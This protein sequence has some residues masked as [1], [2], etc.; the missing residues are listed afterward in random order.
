MDRVALLVEPCLV[1]VFDE[2]VSAG[3]V[4]D[5]PTTL[6]AK[7]KLLALVPSPEPEF[8]GKEGIIA[9][10]DHSPHAVLLSLIEMDL[11]TLEIQIVQRQP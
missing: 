8:N 10:I 11:P 1:K 4:T 2:K 7:E 6:T 3:T 9:Q 5:V